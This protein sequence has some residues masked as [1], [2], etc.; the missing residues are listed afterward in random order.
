MRLAL[1]FFIALG[2]SVSIFFGMQQMIS[3]NANLKQNPKAA[4]HIVYLRNKQESEVKK[5]SRIK[6]KKPPEEIKLTQTKLSPKI[7]KKIKIKSLNVK[8]QKIDIS[9]ISS[10]SGAKIAL[11]KNFLDARMLV[12]NVKRNPRYP[13]KAK[14]RKISGHVQLSFTINTDG[15]VS[16]VAVLDSKPKGYFEKSSVKAI[17]HWKFKA[18]KEAKD[19]VITFNF[20]LAK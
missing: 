19:A 6:P 7:D 20:R 13:R 15:S 5:K 11:G 18:L 9:S 2:I 16:N 17:K 8:H 4:P 1:A 3:L 14:M 12:A 10:L